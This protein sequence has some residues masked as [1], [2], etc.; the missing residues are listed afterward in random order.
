MEDGD[1]TSEDGKGKR[2]KNRTGWDRVVEDMEW[3][4]G[5]GGK[6]KIKSGQFLLQPGIPRTLALVD[7]N[8]RARLGSEST[9]GWS[10]CFVDGSQRWVRERQTVGS[11]LLFCAGWKRRQV[12]RLNWA[13]STGHWASGQAMQCTTRE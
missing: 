11:R 1:E 8:L 9:R 10:E 6:G 7:V 12:R 13:L 4:R 2:W 5:K 3:G